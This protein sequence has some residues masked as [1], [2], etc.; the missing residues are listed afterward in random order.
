VTVSPS[1]DQS[2]YAG[3]YTYVPGTL[4]I[5]AAVTSP[6]P[7][8]PVVFHVAKVVGTALAGHTV[9]VTIDGT[10]FYGRP[11]IT[12]S[13]GRTITALVT[14]D[15]GKVLTVRVTVKSGTALGTHTFTIALANGKKSVVR[16]VLR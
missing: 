10:G 12:S 13:T 2:N 5:T 14:R 16:F 7:P 8:P 15:T 6:P 4:T 9:V 3:T 11:K 1:T